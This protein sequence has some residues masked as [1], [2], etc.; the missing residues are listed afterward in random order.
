[1]KNFRSTPLAA[2]LTSLAVPALFSSAAFAQSQLDGRR[3]VPASLPVSK[4]NATGTASSTTYLRGDGAWQAPAAVS[5][6]KIILS[7]GDTS[8]DV[9]D[10]KLGVSGIL[11]IGDSG[12][13]R[14]IGM[15]AAAAGV[16]GYLLGSDFNT[17]SGKEPSLGLPSTSG[18]VL[19]STA[20]GVRS[21]IA[22]QSGP[23]GPAGATGAAGTNGTNGAAAS[24]SVGTTTTGAAGSAASVTN[25]GTSNAALLNFT[26]PAGP[27]GTGGS[28][29]GVNVV[30][31]LPAP[32]SS[33]DNNYYLLRLTSQKDILYIGAH[34]QSGGSRLA[35]IILAYA[36]NKTQPS[37]YTPPLEQWL[38]NDGSGNKVHASVT[39]PT[40]DLTASVTGDFGSDTNGSYYA[41]GN[42]SY[43]SGSAASAALT[44]T[45]DFSVE[46]VVLTGANPTNKFISSQGQNTGANTGIVY[47]F[48]ISSSSTARFGISTASTNVNLQIGA[49]AANT[50]YHLVG[51]YVSSSQTMTLYVN[52]VSAG[53][54]SLGGVRTNPTGTVTNIGTGD[55]RGTSTNEW[56]GKIYA[57]SL[58]NRALPA[59]E[60]NARYNNL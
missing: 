21:W 58:Y 56:D 19:S 46:V 44:G 24:V 25:S 27:A 42:N 22:P 3:I 39:T 1:M 8:P 28:G 59:S 34:N 55:G 45:G 14:I 5:D 33:T 23:A 41:P 30:S 13:V 16:S 37:G 26:I 60:V 10:N 11:T 49:I 57:V 17:F 12:G 47:E 51:T 54:M 20:A 2:V 7:S 9:L 32:S 52:G 15:G 50:L 48:G 36:L 53:S 4:I 35:Q 6:H 29:G 38:C 18:Y 40:D 31:T 43:A